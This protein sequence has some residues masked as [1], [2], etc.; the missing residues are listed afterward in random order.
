MDTSEFVT[1]TRDL[2]ASSSPI[3]LH[4][5]TFAGNE[6]SYVLDT[7]EST[8]VSSVGEYVARFEEDVRKF[9]NSK[10]AVATSS[11]TS[12]LTTCLL[13]CG[14]S[15]GDLVITQPITFVA[16]CNAIKHLGADPL[17]CD[18]SVDRMSLCPDKVQQFLVEYADLDSGNCFHRPTGKRIAAILP[19]HTFGHAADLSGLEI[20]ANE[21]SIPLIEDA[22]ESLGTTYKNKHT[23]TFGKTAALSFNG[24]KIITTGG[25]GVVLCSDTELTKRAKHLTTTAKV[26]RTFEFLHDEV[27]FNFRM[28]NINAALGVAQMEALSAFVDKKRELAGIY[29]DFFFGSPFEFFAEPEYSNSNYWLNT[30]VCE[31]ADLRNEFLEKSNAEGIATRAVWEPMHNLPMYSNAIRDELEVTQDLRDRVVNIPSSPNYATRPTGCAS[32]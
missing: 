6:R 22:A 32:R 5:P 1:F 20:I 3:P 24:N 27:A 30:L 23:G 26:Q 12:A 7:I 10:G 29:K 11:G 9:T 31:S 18:V 25:G 16:T 4:A 14:V 28:P 19:M 8:F 21:W 17:F 2:Y 13:L 15:A